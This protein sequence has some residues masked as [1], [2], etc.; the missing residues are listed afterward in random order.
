[1]RRR[2]EARWGGEALFAARRVED[3]YLVVI[4]VPAERAA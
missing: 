3:R 1:V 2:L 4:S